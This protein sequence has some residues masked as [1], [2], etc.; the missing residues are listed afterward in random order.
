MK[1]AIVLRG[2]SFSS[3]Y[4]NGVDFRLSMSSLE[5]SLT[6]PLLEQGHDISIYFATYAHEH[7]NELIHFLSPHLVEYKVYDHDISKGNQRDITVLA[8]DTVAKYIHKYDAV[9][10]T[11]FDLKY[12]RKI[13][14]MNIDWTKINLL[15]RE[16]QNMWKAHQRVSDI[17]HIF[18]TNLFSLFL[19]SVWKL[20]DKSNLHKLYG[21][22]IKNGVKSEDIHFIENDFYDSCPKFRNPLVSIVRGV[23][24]V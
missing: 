21:E 18:P 8:L 12:I 4:R 15:W 14:E 5:S 20:K 1:I 13:T 22:L 19:S 3:S 10:L 24:G 2:I 7:Q 16:T 6:I 17:F 11:R 9:I 23:S